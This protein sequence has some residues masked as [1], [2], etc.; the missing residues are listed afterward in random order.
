[1]APSLPLALEPGNAAF[2]KLND[3]K[4]GSAGF[5]QRAHLPAVFVYLSNV[6]IDLQH[7]VR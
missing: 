1:V 5:P 2:M 7:G 3:L 6:F 4:K